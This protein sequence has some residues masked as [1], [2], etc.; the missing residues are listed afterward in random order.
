MGKDE[1][2]TAT[3]LGSDDYLRRTVPSSDPFEV[4]TQNTILHSRRLIVRYARLL[5][6][7]ASLT[8]TP[9]IA[10]DDSSATLHFGNTPAVLDVSAWQYALRASYRRR[11]AKS[12][13]LS[14]GL[15]FQ[16]R[17]HTAFR[18]GSN[19]LPPREGDIYIFGQPPSGDVAV[20][21][22]RIAM[23]NIAP[24]AF[25]E[26]TVG[27]LTL[28]PGLRFEPTVLDG[29]LRNPHS[30][31]VPDI[32]YTRL[33]ATQNPLPWKTGAAQILRYLPNPRL[34]LA[35][36]ATKRMTLT[37]GAGIYGQPP[38][39]EDLSPVF[40]NP[41]IGLSSA[42][43]VTGGVAWRFTGTLGLEVVGFYKRL[44]DLVA[45]NA[46]TSPPVGESLE[47]TG[48]GRCYGG[49]LLL[50]QELLK[51]FFGWVSYSLI[52]SERKDRSES[53]WRLLDYDQTHVL[54]ILGSYEI[55]PGL[56]AGVRFRY[57]TGAPR[58]PVIPG[59]DT[60]LKDYQAEPIFGAQNS[61][62]IP[63]FYSLDV[64]LEKSFVLGRMKLN[65]FLD[66]QNI[67]NRKNP[68]EITYSANFSQRGYITGLPTLAVMGARVEF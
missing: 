32:G 50:R 15:D 65:L 5:S 62:R 39:P 46:L 26:I 52:R 48:I 8:V 20:D 55:L 54:A 41:R 64:R 4:R 45:R 22:W 13:T 66:V 57:T 29:N 59:A 1:D 42:A 18:A 6:D 35:Y 11:V 34:S 17:F 61:I 47:Q 68:E 30:E 53:G 23:V 33:D 40:G 36:R 14:V 27:R 21:R 16:S 51:G 2:L 31:T 9:S 44:Y 58:T 12:A 60:N 28:T 10:T 24:Y 37:A 49:Q 43:H 67:T 63:A 25:T 7:G 19:N 56:Q 3:F 38:Q